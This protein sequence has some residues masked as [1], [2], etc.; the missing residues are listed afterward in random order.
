[1]V[2]CAGC[3]VVFTFVSP[4]C[5]PGVWRSRV[6]A[7]GMQG[8]YC[9]S[10]CYCAGARAPHA[11]D[12]PNGATAPR[13]HERDGICGGVMNLFI[14]GHEFRGI[15]LAPCLPREP[16]QAR[17]WRRCTASFMYFSLPCQLAVVGVFTSPYV[18][19]LYARRACAWS[20]RAASLPC[21]LGSVVALRLWRMA[22]LAA[23]RVCVVCWPLP[24]PALSGSFLHMRSCIC[25]QLHVYVG[26]AGTAPANVVG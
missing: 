7:S 9:L 14:A 15:V 12:F 26:L 1:M 25:I 22:G 17:Q 6:C 23:H 24:W 21:L 2:L 5:R 18:P 4:W 3:A 13:R 11:R 16:S 19:S 8:F 10:A 20:R